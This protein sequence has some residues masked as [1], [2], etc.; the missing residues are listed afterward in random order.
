MRLIRREQILPSRPL[1]GRIFL[2]L[3]V[4]TA[5]VSSA[6]PSAPAELVRIDVTIGKSP[7][8]EVNEPF[9]R[10]SVSDPSI[11][12]VFVVSPRQILIHGKAVGVTSLVVFYPKKNLF[13]DLVVQ[14]DLVV[15]RERLKQIAPRDQIE[16]HGA[17]EAIVL[18]GTV[19]S[20]ELISAVAEVAAAFAPNGKVINLLR[21]KEVKPQEVLIQVQVTEVAR[22]ALRELGFSARF[23]GKVFQ[24]GAFP[25]LPF[26]P[27]LG[28]MS[29]VTAPDLGF[30]DLANLFFAS[31]SREFG[32][33]VRALAERDLLRTLAKP[34]LIT[35]SGKEASFLSGGEFPYPV[36]Q[37]D[38]TITV[39]FKP[40]GVRLI[41]LPVV[42]DGERINLRVEPEVSSLDFSQGV[43]F[44]GF[45]VPVLRK[46]TAF[47]TVNLR[48]GESFAIAGLI[49][50]EVRQSVAKIPLLGDIP[51]LGALFRSTRFQH[52]ETE[53]LF[54]V[55]VKLVGAA[56]PGSPTIPDPATLMELRE[57]EEKEFTL[58][59]GIPGV[60]EVVERPFGKS[61]LP[62]R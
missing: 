32:G 12:D 10:V 37:R 53:L 46:N 39:E 24:G 55:T 48:D 40:F 29:D 27:P 57:E 51:I 22:T 60:G 33:I 30:S 3:L 52:N 31:P 50:N 11:A 35:E 7:V 14:T 15:L 36:A 45:E 54:I 16:V 34:N 42:V 17:R 8:I 1:A 28:L 19:S 62:S 6:R 44:A 43:S 9:D 56:P 21:L 41:F 26:F 47:T 49:N 23:L 20:G 4:T 5:L 59:P 2:V 25:G 38:E 13:F 61:S 58:L 18:Q